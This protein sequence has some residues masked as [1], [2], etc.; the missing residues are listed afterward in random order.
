MGI[1]PLAMSSALRVGKHQYACPKPSAMNVGGTNL[2]PS[3]ADS[4]LPHANWAHSAEQPKL[5][6]H[7]NGEFSS[8]TA[9]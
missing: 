4:P 8:I 3:G 5:T 2:M 1:V 6:A 7:T 9:R